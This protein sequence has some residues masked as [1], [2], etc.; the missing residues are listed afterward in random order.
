MIEY[1]EVLNK[2]IDKRKSV[3]S[4]KSTYKDLDDMYDEVASLFY[5]S[6]YLILKHVSP[7]IEEL[8]NLKNEL[9]KY[10]KNNDIDDDTYSQLSEDMDYYFNLVNNE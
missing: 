9:T 3:I 2:L 6:E 1:S 8:T 5:E 4:N 10:Y 7:Y